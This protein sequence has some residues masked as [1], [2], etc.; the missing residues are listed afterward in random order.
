MAWPGPPG[1]HNRKKITE[2]K[3]EYIGK[4]SLGRTFRSRRKNKFGSVLGV[5]EMVEPLLCA[6]Y[7]M[8]GTV[9]S[10]A[11]IISLCITTTLLGKFS[12]LPF[13]E[14]RLKDIKCHIW[15]PLSEKSWGQRWNPCP[16]GCSVSNFHL[17]KHM[18][19]SCSKI[20]AGPHIAEMGK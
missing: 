2:V 10:S 6:G 9:L 3:L 15:C 8:P 1:C 12:L 14:K 20:V 5:G 7:Y 13:C 4:C 16:A 17:Q 11:F 19:L 18:I